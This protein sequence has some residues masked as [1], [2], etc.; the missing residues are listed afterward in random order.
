[1]THSTHSPDAVG[2]HDAQRR[3][4]DPTPEQIR[5]RCLE[6]QAEWTETQRRQ[7][8]QGSMGRDKLEA[9][10]PYTI[11]QCKLRTSHHP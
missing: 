8:E 6:I 11:P 2:D 5:E 3:P 9:R 7:R 10:E 1:M 4:E